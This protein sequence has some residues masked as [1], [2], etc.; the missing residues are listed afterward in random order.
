MATKPLA[1]SSS[2]GLDGVFMLGTIDHGA[3]DEKLIRTSTWRDLI[4]RHRTL[5]RNPLCG[6]NTQDT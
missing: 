4:R 5:S 3:L 2:P 1:A 6:F